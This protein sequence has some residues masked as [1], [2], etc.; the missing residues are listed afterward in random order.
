M[1]G[2]GVAEM[3][4]HID[5]SELSE[6]IAYD[7]LEGIP[8]SWLQHGNLCALIANMMRD[9]KKRPK[10]FKPSD[11]M[12][13]FEEEETTEVDLTLWKMAMQARSKNSDNRN[14]DRRAKSENR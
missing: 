1:Q 10:P 13:S 9:E 11:F 5:S 6:W 12:P 14:T 2:R 7:Q 8:N 4:R 3:L